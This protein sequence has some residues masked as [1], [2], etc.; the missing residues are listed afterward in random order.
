MLGGKDDEVVVYVGV[1]FELLY[2]VLILYDDV[3]DYDF[4]WWGVF[5]ILGS[6]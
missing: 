5:N 4:V 2:I 1:V 3:I 6:Y